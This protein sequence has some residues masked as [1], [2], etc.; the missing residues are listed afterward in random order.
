MAA[1]P[2]YV[3]IKADGLQA[4]RGGKI[5]FSRLSFRLQSGQMAVINGANGAGKSTL[6][7]LIAGLYPPLA[8]TVCLSAETADNSA[9]ALPLPAFSHYLSDKNAMKP[10]LSVRDNLRFW[11]RFFAPDYKR[12]AEQQALQRLLA[13]VSMAAYADFPFAALSTGQKRR[14]GMS[15][16][17]TGARPLWLLDEPTSGL[18]KAGTALFSRI[19]RE[20]LAGGGLIIAA[21]HMPLGLPA[22]IS[23]DLTDYRPQT[24]AEQF[25]DPLAAG[26]TAD[27]SSGP[28]ANSGERR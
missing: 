20:H 9:A 17:L 3:Q 21:T 12:E 10:Q 19:C 2:Q 8:G 7:R 18:D 26:Q 1:I 6:L 27:Y 22:D 15:R 16:L 25:Y 13:R 5:L 4:S 24:A 28:A 23:L 11:Q 14:I